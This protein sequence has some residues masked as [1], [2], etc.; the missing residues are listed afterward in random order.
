MVAVR[1]TRGNAVQVEVRGISEVMNMLR[2]QGIEINNRVDLEVVKQGNFIQQEV[3]ESIIGRRAEPKSVDTGFLAN[4]IELDVQSRGREIIHP[5]NKKY[6][7]KGTTVK[8]VASF[9]EF[10]TSRIRPR[11][12]FR[13]TE[14]RNSKK[15]KEGIQKSI[16]EAINATQR[17]SKSF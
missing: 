3:Q 2:L 11:R 9:M 5:S 7:K 17:K 4:N 6:S 16:N 8:Q 13:N 12:H 15:V 1:G 10:G 14:K